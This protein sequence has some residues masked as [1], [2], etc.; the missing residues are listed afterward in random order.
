MIRLIYSSASV[1]PLTPAMVGALLTRSRERNE[2]VGISGLLVVMNDD[3]MQVLEGEDEVVDA[4]FERI[5]SDQRHCSLTL[6]SRE[7]ISHPAFAGWSKAFIDARAMLDGIGLLPPSLQNLSRERETQ[8]T[9]RLVRE[10]IDGKWH[11]HLP[12][13]LLPQVVHR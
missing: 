13:G 5:R 6:L 8:R 11:H 9:L 2:A 1:E 4:L 12:S 10:F 3:F 7:I